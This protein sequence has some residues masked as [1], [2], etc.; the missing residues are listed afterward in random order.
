MEWTTVVLFKKDLCC[1][2]VDIR[3]PGIVDAS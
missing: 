1:R 3:I 2:F